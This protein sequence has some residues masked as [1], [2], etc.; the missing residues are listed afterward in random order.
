MP[1]MRRRLFTFFCALSLLLSMTAC[2][3]PAGA[4][5]SARPSRPAPRH[6]FERHI[7]SL[8]ADAPPAAS[9]AS[10]EAL[11]A[12]GADAFSSLI[13]HFDDPAVAADALQQATA[14]PTTVGQACFDLLQQQIEGRWPKSARDFQVLRP[15]NARE[16]LDAN[17]GLTLEELR[18]VARRQSLARAEEALAADPSNETLH[19]TVRFLKGRDRLLK[20]AAPFLPKALAFDALSGIR[21][22]FLENGVL[23]V[24]SP[25]PF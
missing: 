5:E 8:S 2:S 14:E 16:W 7:H 6:D 18:R 20:T 19:R 3:R 9:I 21:L 1:N 13:D 25:P 22:V 24:M 4:R 10:W 23:S 15:G 11:R 17:R 12:A